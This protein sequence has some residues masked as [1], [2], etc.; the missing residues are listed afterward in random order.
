MKGACSFSHQLLYFYSW[1]TVMFYY[2]LPFETPCFMFWSHLT[3]AVTLRTVLAALVTLVSHQSS[4][5]AAKQGEEGLTLIT[6]GRGRKKRRKVEWERDESHHSRADVLL[7]TAAVT[8]SCLSLSLSL[9]PGGQEAFLILSL[10][11]SPDFIVEKTLVGEFF[12]G[13]AVRTTDSSSLYS[14]L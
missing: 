1:K 5:V 4:S 12:S 8:S 9:S 7:K 14:E 2:F 3:T 6:D 10:F 11:L 13:F